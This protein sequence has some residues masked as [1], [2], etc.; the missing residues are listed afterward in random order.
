M[1]QNGLW[2]AEMGVQ[3]KAPHFVIDARSMGVDDVFLTGHGEHTGKL[4]R[5]VHMRLLVEAYS[6]YLSVEK[7]LSDLFDSKQLEGEFRGLRDIETLLLILSPC[8]VDG[9]NKS[10]DK[11]RKI[12]AGRTMSIDEL[13]QKLMKLPVEKE[14]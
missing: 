12:F 5:T 8:F 13:V 1:P 10:R 2:G 7:R 4:F 9:S 14:T 6:S 11:L 3:K